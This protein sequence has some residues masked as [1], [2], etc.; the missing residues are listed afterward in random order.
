MAHWWGLEGRRCEAISPPSLSPGFPFSPS[1]CLP[2][3][4]P[5][6]RKGY[7][8][9]TNKSHGHQTLL[10]TAALGLLTTFYRPLQCADTRSQKTHARSEHM[11]VHTMEPSPSR[12]QWFYKSPQCEVSY[13]PSSSRTTSA[14]WALGNVCGGGATIQQLNCCYSASRGELSIKPIKNGCESRNWFVKGSW[15]QLPL[16]LWPI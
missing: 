16:K 10:T 1:L 9:W 15:C 8:G 6:R 7:W 14:V 3:P 12:W 11:C 4:S 5:A 2:L 13:S